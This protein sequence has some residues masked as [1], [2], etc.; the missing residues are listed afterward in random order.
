M[1]IML[2]T[3]ILISVIIFNSNKLKELLVNICDNH[4]LILS[5]YIIEELEDV[6]NRKFS[7]KKASLSKFLYQ[8]P[9]ELNYTPLDVIKDSEI[10]IRD[11]KDLPILNSAIVSDVD[12]FIT[13]DKDFENVQIEKPVIMTAIEFL[14][15]YN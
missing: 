15:R 2:D 3:N 13:G 6:V 12:I 10:E 5:S 4:T 7:S 1:R 14:E 9:Y 11:P 8:L